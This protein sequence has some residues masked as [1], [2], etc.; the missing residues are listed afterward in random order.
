[1]WEV[2]DEV[3]HTGS[4][5]QDPNVLVMCNSAD[6]CDLGASAAGAL[7]SSVFN[8]RVQQF[9]W[10]LQS[11]GAIDMTNVKALAFDGVPDRDGLRAIVW[12]VGHL[13]LYPANPA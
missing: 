8:D 5:L 3:P 1:M 10:E 9:R 6:W 2:R 7:R 11:K 12:K 13:L 4:Y